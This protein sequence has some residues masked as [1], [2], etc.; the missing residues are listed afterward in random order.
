MTSAVPSNT[1]MKFAAYTL[2]SRVCSHLLHNKKIKDTDFNL[3]PL[4]GARD[5]T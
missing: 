3:Y 5:G 4:F 1:I 2:K